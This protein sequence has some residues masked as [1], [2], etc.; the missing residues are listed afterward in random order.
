MK[1]S[2]FEGIRV[3]ISPGC[4]LWMRGARFGTIRRIEKGTV[5]VI[6][7][8]HPRVRKLARV[9]LDGCKAWL[10]IDEN[11]WIGSLKFTAVYLG[12]H[13]AGASRLYVR[14]VETGAG[15]WLDPSGLEGGK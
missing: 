7:M 9:P 4:D 14:E 15:R 11:R 12:P 13:A 6:K 1:P 5:A 3:E 8:D 2:P 10:V